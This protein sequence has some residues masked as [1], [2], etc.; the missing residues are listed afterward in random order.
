M[1]MWFPL[2]VSAAAARPDP[3]TSDLAIVDSP[4]G[5]RVSVLQE[6][7]FR[8]QLGG[9]SRFD[10]RA[11]FN[12]VNRKL[13][14]PAFNSSLSVT[15][16]LVV[17]T[18]AATITV[19]PPVAAANAP[20]PPTES[21]VHQVSFSCPAG[22]SNWTSQVS[23]AGGLNSSE[24]G[25][26]PVV[27]VSMRGWYVMDDTATLRLAGGNESDL[28]WW[29]HTFAPAGTDLYL[30]CYGND[31]SSGMRQLTSVTGAAPLLPLESYGVWH[32]QCCDPALYTQQGLSELVMAAYK[33]HDVPLDVLN[34]DMSW[35]RPGWSSYSWDHT[36]FPD[37]PALMA[38]L[39]SGDNAYGAQLKLILNHH[40]GGA[41]IGPESEDR[42]AQFAE[43]MGV[44]PALNQTF[45]CDFYNQTYVQSLYR[46]IL[47]PLAD[48]VWIDES[49]ATSTNGQC[50]IG[51]PNLDWNLIANYAFNEL[52]E[53]TFKRRAFT[54][55]RRPGRAD[56]NNSHWEVLSGA[57][58]VGNVGAHRYPGA[59]AGDIDPAVPT[60]PR[61][62]ALFPEAA[63]TQLWL[64]YT[65]PMGPVAMANHSQFDD[66]DGERYVRFVQWGAWSP[67]FW[68]IDEGN[69]NV[70]PWLYGEP[71][72]TALLHAYRLRGALVPYTYTLA[73]HSAVDSW[74]FLRPMWWDHPEAHVPESGAQ[75]YFGAV[76]VRPVTTYNGT[77]ATMGSHV[78]VWLPPGEWTSWD[79][80]EHYHGPKNMRVLVGL[81]QTPLFVPQ[82][83]VLP[84]WPPGRRTAPP[85]DRPIVWTIWAASG[86]SSGSGHAYL[87]DG[88]SLDYREGG[89][90]RFLT[91]LNYTAD[92][93]MLMAHIAPTGGVD[94]GP[95]R[96]RTVLQLRGFTS[97]TAVL[98]NGKLLPASQGEPGHYEQTGWWVQ[99]EADGEPACPAG[100]WVVVCPIE[101]GAAAV[102]IM[103]RLAKAQPV[104]TPHNQTR[105]AG[106][107]LSPRSKITNDDARAQGLVWK[108]SDAQLVTDPLRAEE[109]CGINL[110]EPKL[111]AAL[112][113]L[114]DKR[115]VKDGTVVIDSGAA[116]GGEGC[117]LASLLAPRIVHLVE[118]L[119]VNVVELYQRFKGSS[120]VTV[121]HA[122]L[123]EN[124]SDKVQYVT[125]Y[126][127]AV[128]GAT[129]DI[130]T[131]SLDQLF[132][133]EWKGQSLGFLHL[134]VEGSELKALRGGNHTIS[135]DRPL[136]TAELV[137]EGCRTNCL[138]LC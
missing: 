95:P 7:L 48:W 112:K 54:L 134:D 5:A 56:G 118:P 114:F 93:S 89:G 28:D 61:T 104:G 62:V 108:A 50:G 25:T 65:V 31:F 85:N 16:G 71:Y 83:L 110:Q 29:Q 41:V 32:A 125:T 116:R 58:L 86:L 45:S 100:S 60:L 33:E 8:L 9:T 101:A 121:T 109:E 106:R 10:E 98:V 138:L 66:F 43:A 90:S 26:L 14:V 74:P 18:A 81:A 30:F 97:P 129:A 17:T 76:L 128:Q 55:N 40:P 72:Q 24:G 103:I 111:R 69:I 20:L 59:F 82:G 137:R 34:L 88:E 130:P 91:W 92:A 27:P 3:S 127:K 115:F 123:A 70:L 126:A 136:F 19:W 133:V 47:A 132:S 119:P 44:D 84:M 99:P 87:D 135:R 53:R 107:A 35:H 39:K 52:Q 122:A 131:H 42:Y 23:V 51:P 80:S 117:W 22:A 120:S 46:A 78:D 77:A 102:D 124:S 105:S 57:A 15:A 94:D 21:S 68:P 37:V 49:G 11:T 13:P 1:A 75:Y 38:S 6:G 64:A 36:R 96:S 67:I 63:A 2:L 79:A 113:G 4:W 73:W 12:V